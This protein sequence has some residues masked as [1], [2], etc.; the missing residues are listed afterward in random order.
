VIESIRQGLEEDEFKV[1][2][3]KLRQWFEMPRR[4]V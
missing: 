1:S 3:S 2:I 4:T